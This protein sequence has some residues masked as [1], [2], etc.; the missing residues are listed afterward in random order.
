MK[1]LY[2]F[3]CVI[4]AVLPYS[5]LAPWIA[6]NDV[7]LSLLV[8]LAAAHPVSA[9]AW[10]D[11]SVSAV[12]LV[13]FVVVEGGRLRMSHL[14]IPIVCTFIIGVSFALPLF[15]LMRETRLQKVPAAA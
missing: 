8:R 15:L 1:K 14:W 9:A 10:L 4:G 12:V 6:D 2:F 13:C 5:Q 3:F 7:S 11:L